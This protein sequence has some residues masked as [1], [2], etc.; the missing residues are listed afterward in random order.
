M[1]EQ[2][3]VGS[4]R[5]Q[6]V[7]VNHRDL[8]QLPLSGREESIRYVAN[9]VV[10]G[11]QT[12]GQTCASC[13]RVL[14]QAT[15]FHAICVCCGL[16]TCTDAQCQVFCAEETC[17]HAVCAECRRSIGEADDGQT[18]YLCLPHYEEWE[19]ERMVI[20]LLVLLGVVVLGMMIFFWL[21]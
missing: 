8:G 15:D 11:D 1:A 6:G 17:R 5:R 13:G 7:S 4:V 20:G 18:Q 21:G 9:T 3:P 19:R 14:L 16:P 10:R 2:P 12:V